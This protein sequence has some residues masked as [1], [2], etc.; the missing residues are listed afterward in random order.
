[1][2]STQHT[3]AALIKVAEW[4]TILAEFPELGNEYSASYADLL[5]IQKAYGCKMT[6]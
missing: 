1:M 2:N 4:I 3:Q 6:H 5:L